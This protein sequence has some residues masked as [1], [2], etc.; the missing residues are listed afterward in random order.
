[1]AGSAL[2]FNYK[3]IKIGIGLLER[4]DHGLQPGT[5][6]FFVINNKGTINSDFGAD[7]RPGVTIETDSISILVQEHR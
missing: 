1:M 4:H 2:S 6:T 7:L 3:T 5:N